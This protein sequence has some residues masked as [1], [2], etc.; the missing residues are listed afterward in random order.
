MVVMVVC[1]HGQKGRENSLQTHSIERA[2]VY[3]Q[4]SRAEKLQANVAQSEGFKND[5]VLQWI[6]TGHSA[7]KT[8]AAAKGHRFPMVTDGLPA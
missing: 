1:M 5:A 2:A 4:Q 8:F 6:H 7:S 3:R